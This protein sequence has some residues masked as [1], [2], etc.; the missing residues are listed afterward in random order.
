MERTIKVSEESY[1]DL[2]AIATEL[3]RRREQRITFDDAIQD[4]VGKK[5]KNKNIMKFAG[6]WKLSD[7]E[8]EM[9]IKD[10]YKERKIVSR[11]L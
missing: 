6:S 1:R 3:Q 4:L 7:E 8:A 9:L 11:R 5:K 2:L 10:I